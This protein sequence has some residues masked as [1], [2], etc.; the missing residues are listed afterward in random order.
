M[1]IYVQ[2]HKNVDT[3]HEQYSNINSTLTKPKGI[4]IGFYKL[5][6]RFEGKCKVHKS[7]LKKSDNLY[8]S[9]ILKMEFVK[10]IYFSYFNYAWI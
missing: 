9:V 5:T 10:L 6:L 2:I 7:F 4:Q 8:E 1:Y 3:K